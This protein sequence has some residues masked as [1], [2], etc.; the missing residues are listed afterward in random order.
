MNA[1]VQADERVREA[2]LQMDVVGQ[3]LALTGTEVTTAD[4][5]SEFGVTTVLFRRSNG[6]VRQL[7]A[8]MDTTLLPGDTLEADFEELIPAPLTE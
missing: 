7:I 4:V 5:T 8:D 1:Q 3:F 6:D 2:R